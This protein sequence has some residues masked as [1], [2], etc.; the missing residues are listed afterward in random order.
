MPPD[1]GSAAFEFV[2]RLITLGCHHGRHQ[3]EDTDLDGNGAVLTPRVAIVGEDFTSFVG[4]ARPT[5]A[6][7]DSSK[8]R[9]QMPRGPSVQRPP[10]FGKDEMHVRATGRDGW[11][12]PSM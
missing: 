1:T 8:S 7:A 4:A 3:S 9:G 5:A 10:A 2:E 6:M 11:P 12:R